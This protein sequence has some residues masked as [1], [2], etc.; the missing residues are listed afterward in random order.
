MWQDLT[1]AGLPGIRNIVQIE[2]IRQNGPDVSESLLL[3]KGVAVHLDGDRSG[4]H[5]CRTPCTRRMEWVE[6]AV[7]AVWIQLEARREQRREYLRRNG[8]GEDQRSSQM[9]L[10]E[11]RVSLQQVSHGVPGPGQY[12]HRQP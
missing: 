9:R 3:Q 7:I 1:N 5:S 8:I 4:F 2:R 10:G 12:T 11:R 6:E